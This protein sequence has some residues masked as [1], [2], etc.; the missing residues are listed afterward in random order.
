MIL[1]DVIRLGSTQLIGFMKA[2]VI[3]RHIKRR[4][5]A[6]RFTG[7]NV[8]MRVADHDGFVRVAP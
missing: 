7:K 6:S 3:A 8:D 4:A 5:C 1:E 2:M